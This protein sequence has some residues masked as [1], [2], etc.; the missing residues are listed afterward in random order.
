VTNESDV[1]SANQ[2]SAENVID[3]GIVIDFTCS[4]SRILFKV[5]N[6]V[7]EG[8]SSFLP[9]EN[10]RVIAEMQGIIP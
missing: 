10:R 3:A 9:K 8:G 2:S 4:L 1:D 5:T 6:L 7:C